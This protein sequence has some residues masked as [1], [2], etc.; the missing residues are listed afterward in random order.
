[1]FGPAAKNDTL[2]MVRGIEAALKKD[3]DE[4]SWMS[5]ETKHAARGKLAAVVDR[6]GYPDKWKDYS[7]VRVDRKDALGNRQRAFAFE[8]SRTL[9]KI[10]RPVDRTEWRMTPPTVNAYYSADRNNINFP[11][12]ILQ[13][14]FYREGRDAA[15]N[16]GGIGAVVGH[17]L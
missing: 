13:P 5:D 8:T 6:I 3:I 1:R 9:E 2:A 7:S 12:G 10:G 17:E 16:Y 14:P 4:A 11:A 15:V